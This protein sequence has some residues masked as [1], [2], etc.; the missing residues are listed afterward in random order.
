MARMATKKV[1]KEKIASFNPKTKTELPKI[2]KL[3]IKTY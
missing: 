3:N 2:K 1:A